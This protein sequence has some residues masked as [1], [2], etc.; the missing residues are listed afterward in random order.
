M[1]M[2]TQQT[3]LNRTEQL[4]ELEKRLGAEHAKALLATLEQQQ[5][6]EKTWPVSPP[7]SNGSNSDTGLGSHADKMQ[8]LFTS[9]LHHGHSP[10][11][12]TP[13]S[14]VEAGGSDLEDEDEEE[15]EV[16][17]AED[18]ADVSKDMDEDMQELLQEAA[19]K[20]A[21]A[22]AEAAA[23]DSCKDQLKA[24]TSQTTSS[25]AQGS[26]ISA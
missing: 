18:E 3:L 8:G 24:T 13:G 2:H 14:Q 15:I 4:K 6:A 26:E 10:S 19:D 11:A 9:L 22:Q 17:E 20:A 12:L 21:A 25:L 7:V 5:Q 23:E 16:G 1:E